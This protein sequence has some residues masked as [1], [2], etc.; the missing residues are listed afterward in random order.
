MSFLSRFTSKRSSDRPSTSRSGSSASQKELPTPSP[1]IPL[2]L[3]HSSL[4][5]ETTAAAPLLLRSPPPSS[6]RTSPHPSS[7][8]EGRD[9]D[10][11]SLSSSSSLHQDPWVEVNGTDSPRTARTRLPTGES[12]RDGKGE[13]KDPERERREWVRCEKARLGVGEVTL[14]LDECGAV[15][16][17]RGLTTLGLF[18]PYRLA[19][20]PSA[21]LNLILLFLDYTA[22]FEIKARSP[23][24]SSIRG[25]EA[26]KAVLLHAW[27]E[28]LRYA[29]VVDVV[30]V[31]KWALRHLTYP[32]TT[33]FSG[34]PA[35]SLSFY[36]SLFLPRALSSPS[37]F[38]AFLLPSLPPSS[39]RL[40]LSTLALVGH[41]AAFAPRNAMSARRLC[42]LLGV[43][44]FGLAQAEA[45]G[46]AGGQGGEGAWESLY[47]RWQDAGDVLEGCLKAY[48]REQ[49]EL[50]PT[51]T[52]LLEGYEEYVARQ[53][54][55][56]S[57]SSS[58][59][60][61][62]REGGEGEGRQVAVIRV[63]L[64][65]RAGG[66]EGWKK[67]GEVEVNDQRT[68][69]G[70]GRGG[71]GKGKEPMRRKP[72]EI[73][74]AAMEA[75]E[76]VGREGEAGRV[77]AVVLERARERKGK[78]TGEVLEEE[79]VRVLSLLGLD[80]LSSTGRNG[81]E[82]HSPR[83]RRFSLDQPN[84][85]SSSSPYSS[86]T[87]G[88]KSVGNLLSP[89]ANSNKRNITPTWDSFA[90]TGFSSSS[91]PFSSSPSPAAEADEFGL[92]TTSSLSSRAA[93]LSARRPNLPSTPPTTKLL[94]VSIQH[95][96]EE[97]ADVWLDTLC[98]S[99]SPLSPVAGWPGLLVS[100]LRSTVV[101]QIDALDLATPTKVDHILITERLLPLSPTSPLSSPGLAPPSSSLNRALS[102]ASSRT[103]RP[104]GEDASLS[105]R[106][107]WRRRAS[108]I[109]NTGSSSSSL[110]PSSS[111]EASSSSSEPSSS[112]G[113]SFSTLLPSA[114]RSRKSFAYDLS[115]APPVPA[116]P[117]L[118][119]LP[120]SPPAGETE[121]LGTP[122]PALGPVVSAAGAREGKEK[123][124][125]EGGGEKGG[126]L[127]RALSRRKSSLSQR[128]SKASLTSRRSTVGGGGGKSEAVKEEEETEPR[129]SSIPLTPTAVRNSFVAADEPEKGGEEEEAE[130]YNVESPALPPK[131]EQVVESQEERAAAVAEEDEKEAVL[132]PW[133]EMIAVSKAKE[134]ASVPL[135]V[136]KA[137]H[138]PKSLKP[139]PSPFDI[140][141]PMEPSAPLPA[142]TVPPS[143]PLPSPPAPLPSPAPE[144]VAAVEE[145]LV[146]GSVESSLPA[147]GSSAALHEHEHT[148][149]AAQE[150]ACAVEKP[151]ILALP[152]MGEQE[153]VRHIEEVASPLPAS[154]SPGA[155]EGKAEE[156]EYDLDLP[157]VSEEEKE[158]TTTPT[159]KVDA[160]EET[161]EEAEEQGKE[162]RFSEDT[163]RPPSVEG[164]EK[165]GVEAQSAL[166]SAAVDAEESTTPSEEPPTAP[167]GLGLS[168]T[169]ASPV[170]LFVEDAPPATPRKSPLPARAS[171]ASPRTP[172][173]PSLSPDLSR[174]FSHASQQAK[175]PTLP[176]KSPTPSSGS[177]ASTSRKFLAG[178][179]SLLRRKKSGLDSTSP[180]SSPASTTAS[181]SV[182]DRVETAKE[183]AKREKEEAKALR[184]VREEELRKEI[185][186]R[187]AA[188]PVSNVKARV[189]EIEEEHRAEAVSPATPSRVRTLS[190]VNDSPTPAG[191]MSR[192]GSLAGGGL[193]RPGSM[194]SLT[195]VSAAAAGGAAAGMPVFGA[196]TAAKVDEP[197][198]V[199]EKELPA[200]PVEQ[201]EGQ[202]DD[203]PVED[204]PTAEA[205]ETIK[206]VEP[207]ELFEAAQPVEAEESDVPA[208]EEAAPL[209]EV[210]APAALSQ[211]T[212]APAVEIASRE[213][214]TPALQV[215]S[216]QPDD[217]H[218]G[219]ISV[220]SNTTPAQEMEHLTVKLPSALDDL[221]SPIPSPTPQPDSA[222][223]VPILVEADDATHV[224]PAIEP[225]VFVVDEPTAP[226]AEEQPA[227]PDMVDSPVTSA[228]MPS[229]AISHDPEG[230]HTGP[231]PSISL[232]SPPPA[233]AQESEHLHVKVPSSLEDLPSPM[234]SPTPSP[235]EATQVE[236]LAEDWTETLPEIHPPVFV[237]SQKEE[238]RA[239][240]DTVQAE[241]EHGDAP[242]HQHEASEA[243]FVVEPEEEQK[244]VE[245][246]ESAADAPPASTDFSLSTPPSAE[247]EATT[248]PVKEDP[249]LPV[250][251]DADLPPSASTFPSTPTK[252]TASLP[253]DGT[254]LASNGVHSTPTPAAADDVF[255]SSPGPF[256]H[257]P[258]ESTPTRPSTLPPQQQR[259]HMIR[260][261]PST[262]SIANSIATTTSF[263]TADGAPSSTASSLGE[264][265]HWEAPPETPF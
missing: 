245:A 233:P 56:F 93:T 196:V 156:G 223:P 60:T 188:T 35:P 41:V 142:S 120:G 230:D 92:Y 204:A 5:S 131:D 47:K 15:I 162:Q 264:D 16:R 132:E 157:A 174:S 234:P 18:R 202:V 17:S 232:T 148:E 117:T 94:S 104:S 222:V 83:R 177:T 182:K 198:E 210:A 68:G 79:T 101:S 158:E 46:T 256:P 73:F 29:E 200:A 211:E 155:E 19:E 221:P 115:T 179:G 99:R 70:G 195:G 112:S 78:E 110:L 197:F 163:V 263:Q 149:Q 159:F 91:S 224:L 187:K 150:P 181:P 45:E 74:L 33:S 186:E 81:D 208:V 145:A 63:E 254:P 216:Q 126:V 252:P 105:P 127:A 20:S 189:K 116:L 114:R 265:E 13:K 24:D 119:P 190:G 1:L 34:A 27:R 161:V 8:T 205:P 61:A 217:D 172:I 199:E 133:K 139:L 242:R 2:D 69:L 6:S 175:S 37:A 22:E 170:E 76:A 226:P 246:I 253:S 26:S 44:L 238:E 257:A 59:S 86:N 173:S 136:E 40:L 67:A 169:P 135:S 191:G 128:A 219:P 255:S 194:V 240:P 124:K 247:D 164:E 225:P 236:P 178:V 176:P 90:T 36:T 185:K 229:L 243:T 50:P 125:D 130:G 3:P 72:V 140:D 89:S 102:S 180:P 106:K 51:L 97:F 192:S 218:T 129:L 248:S 160:P 14:V 251:A 28:E 241:P 7:A 244:E 154:S 88:A 9:S 165:E 71:D 138:E 249:A 203:A 209:E 261:S 134:E 113:K 212:T 25:S 77:W 31:V 38:S 215:A 62:A 168:H 262:Y 39:Q 11:H 166:T 239:E 235:L 30:A 206:P 43:Y 220:P 237:S 58:T 87:S 213:S 53:V 107:K 260:A 137:R 75:G 12:G 85:T 152:T 141:S 250:R 10:L 228:D 32:T 123:E 48:L 42:R 80:K 259:E 100:K 82:S 144:S 231:I 183:A 98:E 121:G 65:T 171:A 84:F 201:V 118:P 227:Q 143:L 108:A 151:D 54:G 66:M 122:P 109:F 55:R 258:V 21:Q 64:E 103:A 193:A 146:T 153:E 207:V 96:D 147:S 214:V 4:L 95:V 49:T 184:K 23:L 57:S 111:R 167:V 52:A